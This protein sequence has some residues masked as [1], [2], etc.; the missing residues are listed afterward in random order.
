MKKKILLF[1]LFFACTL[2]FS[3]CGSDNVKAGDEEYPV[4]E[5]TAYTHKKEADI[6]Y[7]EYYYAVDEKTGVV[8]IVYENQHQYGMTPA[9]NPDGTPVTKE[10]LLEEKGNRD[11]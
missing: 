1:S 8:Y 10:Q 4:P 5:I 6:K 11:K 3:G 9:L 7:A 2:M